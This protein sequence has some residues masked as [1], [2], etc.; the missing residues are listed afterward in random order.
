M[1]ACEDKIRT[2][3]GIEL[4]GINEKMK[5]IWRYWNKNAK[6]ETGDEDPHEM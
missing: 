4:E 2:N 1:L 6:Q 3:G 5:E